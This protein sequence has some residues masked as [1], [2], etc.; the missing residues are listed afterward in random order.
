MQCCSLT[1]HFYA[2]SASGINCKFYGKAFNH[3]F[4]L[5]RR[6]KEYCPLK[7][8]KREM[9]ETESQTADPEDDASTVTTHGS[10]SPMSGDND[11][12]TEKEEADPW[13]PMVEE[14]MQKHKTA[15]QEINM[16]LVYSGLDEQAAEEEA[17]SNILLELQKELESIYLHRLQWIQKLWKDPLHTKILQDKGCAR[18][19]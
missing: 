10:E 7:G 12:E 15:F 4:Y 8:E 14:V 2:I 3:G 11:I 1:R 16:N 5:R 18:E 17:Y 13:M 6:E 9:S 19:R